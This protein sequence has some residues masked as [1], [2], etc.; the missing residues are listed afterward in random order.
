[1][2]KSTPERL[3]YAREYRRLHRSRILEYKRGYRRRHKRE[4]SK[5]LV[6]YRKHRIAVDPVYKA[7]EILRCEFRNRIKH[8]IKNNK[9]E[10][11]PSETLGIDLDGFRKHI[12]SKFIGRMSWTNYGRVWHL[13]HIEPLALLD[14]HSE[15]S[16]KKFWHYTN[17]QPLFK[18][19]N[20]T[21]SSSIDFLTSE[22]VFTIFVR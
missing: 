17:I 7:R 5:K 15:N 21:K 18:K 2:T 16:I 8:A 14:P 13:D 19:D 1:M 3:A 22:G 12:E 20:W 4:L 10:L 6:E 11:F 9:P